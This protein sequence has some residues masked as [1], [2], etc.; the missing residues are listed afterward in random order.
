[1]YYHKFLASSSQKR[2]TGLLHNKSMILIS[3]PLIAF[4]IGICEDILD[5]KKLEDYKYLSK[6]K[7]GWIYILLKSN[8]LSSQTISQMVSYF[9]E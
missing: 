2:K 9:L 1:M 6:N 5:K 7:V 4:C 8:L 3:S